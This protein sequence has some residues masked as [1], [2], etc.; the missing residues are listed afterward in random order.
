MLLSCSKSPSWPS[1]P[2]CRATIVTHMQA[3]PPGTVATVHHGALP[4]SRP[5]S[6]G[7][8]VVCMRAA[9]EVAS[10]GARMPC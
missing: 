3:L 5:R 1:W 4:R 2:R 10:G 7:A 8:A 6:R 9:W